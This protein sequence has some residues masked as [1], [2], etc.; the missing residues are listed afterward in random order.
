MEETK[1]MPEEIIQK[2]AANDL[3][4]IALPSD[5]GGAGLN[6]TSNI[7]A[8]HE[9]S[10]V[11]AAVGV[12]LSVHTSVG[13]KP[14]IQFGTEEQK[15]AYIPKLASG[16]YIGAFA[17]TEANAGSDASNI[18][19]RAAKKDDHYVLNGEKVFITN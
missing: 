16:Q 8:I 10:K 15:D 12:L 17:L 19:L 18:R 5:Y 13:T 14:I 2:L 6:F 3:F 9:V 1:E 11:S 4:G 7:I